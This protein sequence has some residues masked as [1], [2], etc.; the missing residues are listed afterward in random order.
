MF[1]KKQG[2]IINAGMQTKKTKQ[3]QPFEMFGTTAKKKI[4]YITV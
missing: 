2:S 1:K 4:N 3:K